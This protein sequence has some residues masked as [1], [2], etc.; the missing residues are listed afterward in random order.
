MTPEH[1]AGRLYDAYGASLYRYALM[2]LASREGAEDVIQQV[3]AA[4]L[5]TRRRRIDD[6]ERYLRRAVRNACYSALRH[7]K[8]RRGRTAD[9]TLLEVAAEA[10]AVSEEDRIAL[11]EAIRELPPDQR[12]VIHLHIFE[13]RTFK[14]VAEMTGEPLNTIAS[15]Y[16]YALEKLKA[17]LTPSE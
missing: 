3:F 7:Q 12:E 6:E 14:D 13:G 5:D 1:E 16:R 15:R 8:V 10:P 4:L 9:D 2:I 11:A 17:T